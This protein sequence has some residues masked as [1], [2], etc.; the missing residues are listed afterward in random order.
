MEKNSSP[1]ARLYYL[2][3]PPQTLLPTTPW[4]ARFPVG[5][6]AISVGLFGLIAAWRRAGLHGWAMASD[7]ADM[8]LWPACAIWIASLIL[9]G[10]KCTRHFARVVHEFKH[11]VQSSL[12]ALLPLSILLMVI[13]FNRPEQGI[14]LVLT[15]LALTMHAVIGFRLVSVLSTG[16]LPQNAVSP[17]LY[18]PIVGGALV[19]AMT[20][21]S[22]GYPGWGALLFGTGLSGWALLE[23]RILSRLFE[24]PL[25]ENLRPTMGVELAP[26]AIATI[27][28]AILWPQLP[29]DLLIIG[30]GV[31]IAPF[32][33]VLARAG[34]WARVP[35]SVGFW[36]FSFPLAA[37][38]A[39]VVET[40]HRGGWP[41]WI[42]HVALLGATAVI[43][44]L[45]VRTLILLAQRRFVPAE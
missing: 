10:V 40:V 45:S 27:T 15:L 43:A 26:P 35:F 18:I 32:V 2:F 12:Q 39:A 5:V 33:G 11:P 42:G 44:F 6:F 17:A 7:I 13:Q 4:L 3:N 1:R 29:G 19:G 9:Y 37:F 20:L 31:A 41:A 25:A 21:A 23:A 30:L 8:L 34:W 22:L 36:S 16:Q 38:A 14:W 28:A 24:G